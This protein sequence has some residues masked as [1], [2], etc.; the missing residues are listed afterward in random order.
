[1]KT[2]FKSQ[3]IPEYRLLTD[4]QI[5]EIHQ[6]T[7]KVLETTGVKVL[8]NAAVQLLQDAGCRTEDQQIV[9]I[10]GH[11]VEDSIKS[12][13]SSVPIY[14]RNGEPAMQLGGTNV[15]FGM[16]T[17]LLNTW[18]LK[19]GGLRQS[20]LQDV[21]DSAVVGD[22]CAQI[23]F[24]ASNAFPL[25]VQENLA[26]VLEFKAMMEHSAKPI[27]FTAGASA[28]LAVILEMATE[29]RGGE[30]QLR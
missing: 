22:Y 11:L 18:D 8:N 1:M 5:R 12:A 17:D 2:G 30:D 23:D 16:G 21:I 26:F 9:K 20:C 14:S 7:L 15:Y 25:D 13:P 19:T 27:Y 28:D 10:P 24:I 6:A 4:G 3:C 29:I